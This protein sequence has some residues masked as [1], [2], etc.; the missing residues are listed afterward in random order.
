MTVMK[1]PA[2]KLTAFI[3]AKIANYV[4]PS[5]EGVPRGQR[6][7]MSRE[8]YAAA[9]WR[10]T[11]LSWP[12]IATLAGTTHAAVRQFALD[13][14]FKKTA[15][16]L[17]AEYAAEYVRHLLRL[18]G[19]VGVLQLRRFRKT[20]GRPDVTVLDVWL[21]DP[22]VLADAS[23]YGDE[24]LELLELV[25]RDYLAV[26][27]QPGKPKE[28][29]GLT[30]EEL[31]AALEADVDHRPVLLDLCLPKDLPRRT[32]MLPGA[33]IHAPSAL[34]RWIEELPR[35]RPIAVYCI[36][37]FQVSGTAVTELR[38]RGYNAR[39]LIGGIT[40]WHAI[41]GATVP[42]DTSTYEKAT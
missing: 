4:P 9:C 41:G 35:D 17:V 38:R 39:A 13:E 5:R 40:A 14:T 7:G 37:G 18:A 12:K 8:K 28:A 15:A 3:K 24:I 1:V 16:A 10:L 30:A 32:D 26:L 29:G 19:T 23:L 31:T 42:L 2:G 34:P 20:E 36:C 22:D 21:E 25:E 6:I 27:T 33:T 11:N